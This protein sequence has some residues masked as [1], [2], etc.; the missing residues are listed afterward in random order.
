MA[1][2]KKN[3]FFNGPDGKTM[4]SDAR[5]SFHY[6]YT[7]ISP[8]MAAIKEGLGSDYAMV[9]LDVDKQPFDGAKTYKLHLPANPPAKDFWSF[10]LYDTQTRSMLQTSQK[11]PT[12]GSQDTGLKK[13]NDGSYDIYIGP[14]APIGHE[15]NWLESIPGKGWF[16]ILRMYGPLKPWIDKTWR[17]SEVQLA[18]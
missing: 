3:V 6:V 7:C 9:F 4:N 13:N 11:F 12:V 18:S 16:G 15:S 5:T 1:Y 10:T 2:L 8:A 17:P 14:K